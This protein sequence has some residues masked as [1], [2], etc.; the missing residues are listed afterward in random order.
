MIPS[1]CLAAFLLF[2]TK[3]K[4]PS[5]AADPITDAPITIPAITPAL[6]FFFGTP[7]LTVGVKSG[8]RVSVIRKKKN[9]HTFF[10]LTNS[11]TELTWSDT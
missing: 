2:F 3:T 6:L 1:C 8:Q 9:Y 10:K 7:F 5:K 4:I 11:V